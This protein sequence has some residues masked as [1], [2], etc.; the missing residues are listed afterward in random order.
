MRS[1]IIHQHSQVWP[2]LARF[3]DYYS[4]FWGLG[5]IFLVVEPQGALTCM[6]ITLAILAYSGQFCGLLVTIFG[7]RAIFIVAEPLGA[8]TYQSSTVTVLSDSDPF[9]GLLPAPR[10]SKNY[11]EHRTLTADL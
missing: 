6:T 5:A 3:V 4:P 10:A 7:S 1:R 11:E 9:H 2:I 8:L